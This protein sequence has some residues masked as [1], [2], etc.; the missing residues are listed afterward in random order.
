MTPA[1]RSSTAPPP[2]AFTGHLPIAVTTPDASRSAATQ[3]ESLPIEVPPRNSAAAALSFVSLDLIAA[4]DGNA[5]LLNV[6]S[7]ASRRLLNTALRVSRACPLGASRSASVGDQV[8]ATAAALTALGNKVSTNSSTSARVSP[9]STTP[10]THASQYPLVF[11]FRGWCA[12]VSSIPSRTSPTH[13]A[14]GRA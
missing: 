11:V 14:A 1:A 5:T 6:S 10:Y 12:I 8:F 2:T 7:Y 3:T 9:H 4:A 13:L